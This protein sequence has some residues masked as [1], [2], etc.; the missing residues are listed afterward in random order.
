MIS[1]S[2]LR[3]EDRCFSFW[4]L[5]RGHL[6]HFQRPILFYFQDFGNAQHCIQTRF[7]IHTGWRAH[8]WVLPSN[9]Y[10]IMIETPEA[11]LVAGMKCCDV[12]GIGGVR[13]CFAFV[14]AVTAWFTRSR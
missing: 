7:R 9:H 1:S 14:A 13:F 2:Y 3:C 8:A 6:F 11:N 12:D 4:I 10:H 5:L